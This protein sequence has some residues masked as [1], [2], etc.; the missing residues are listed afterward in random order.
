MTQA[1]PVRDDLQVESFLFYFC[2]YKWP[3][4][5]GIKGGGK[6]VPTPQPPTTPGRVLSMVLPHSKFGG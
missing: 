3:Q 2:F 6:R 4:G 5:L 1:R